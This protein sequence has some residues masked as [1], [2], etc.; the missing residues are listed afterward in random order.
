LESEPLK[1]LKAKKK[2]WSLLFDPE[3]LVKGEKE[4]KM[5]NFKLSEHEL[6]K[7]ALLCSKLRQ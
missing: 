4:L 7:Q 3:K 2:P 5:E 1:P 6:K